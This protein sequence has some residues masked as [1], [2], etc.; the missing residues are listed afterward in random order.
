MS[1]LDTSGAQ[2]ETAPGPRRSL[3]RRSFHNIGAAYAVLFAYRWL[4]HDQDKVQLSAH[5]LLFALTFIALWTSGAGL[6][7][8]FGSAGAPVDLRSRRI[9]RAAAATAALGL[10]TYVV[11]RPDRSDVWFTLPTP[12]AC[13][14]LALVATWFGLWAAGRPKGAGR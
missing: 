7:R 14:V 3:L 2:P 5:T 8:R 11:L 4:V 9:T 12:V 13:A 1:T 6:V 10:L